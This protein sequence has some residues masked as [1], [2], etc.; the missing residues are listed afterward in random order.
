[1][2][3]PNTPRRRSIVSEGRWVGARIDTVRDGRVRLNTTP[4]FLRLTSAS[5]T[6]NSRE[7]ENGESDISGR[8]QRNPEHDD[9]TDDEDG[10]AD[11]DL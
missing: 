11:A 9:D 8:E 1:M 3:N 10:E 2:G 7:A 5:G 4:A 6:P